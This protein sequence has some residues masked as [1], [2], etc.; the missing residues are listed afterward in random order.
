[1]P[2]I[3]HKALP[4][5][6]EFIVSEEPECLF[7]GAFGSGKTVA[8]CLKVFN[9]AQRKGAREGLCRKHLVSL[10]TTTLKTLLEG[11]G[12]FAPVIPPGTYEHRRA[13]CEINIIGG[14]QI[15]Y[16]GL[17]DP[18]KHGSRQLTGC[19]LDEAIEFN[20]TDYTMLLGRARVKCG[21]LVNQV[22]SACNPGAPSHFLAKRFAMVGESVPHNGCR[23]WRSATFENKHLPTTYVARMAAL[24]GVARQRYY[25]GLWVGA[26]G[27]V[28]DRWDRSIHVAERPSEKARVVLCVD[29]GY[30]NP[31]VV[32]RLELDGDGRAHVAAE[33]YES[34]M[35][36]ADKVQA[37]R[38]LGGRGAEAVVVDPS[39]AGLIGALKDAGMPAEEADNAVL[40]GIARVQGRLEVQGDG[41][42]R[43]TVS[44]TCVNLIREMELYEWSAKANGPAKDSPRKDNDHAPDA[45]RY[46]LAHI[47]V[48]P[49]MFHV[50]SM[51]G[52]RGEVGV[53]L[54]GSRGWR[55]F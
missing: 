20:E 47:D 48:A 49:V 4:K 40:D 32:L 24:S 16:F 39:A 36:T 33:Y 50:G 3:R 38:E 28:Y 6:Y 29:D 44:P 2:D 19:G 22:Y 54:G 11:D 1:M 9:R 12:D 13:D 43:L 25:E 52:E 7:S 34:K 15:V 14:G 41:M 10:K 17:D 5:Q 45:L 35:Q 46:G 21:D 30:V 23:G 18:E 37:V 53:T 8:L 31:F 51:R 55:S 42:P 27:L 26:E